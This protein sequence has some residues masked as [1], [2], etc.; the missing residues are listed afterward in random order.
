MKTMFLITYNRLTVNSNEERTE[1][2]AP[3]AFYQ[4]WKDLNTNA[5]T[6]IIVTVFK[7]IPSLPQNDNT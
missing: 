2:V 3:E 7:D 5:Y 6:R 1:L 4:W